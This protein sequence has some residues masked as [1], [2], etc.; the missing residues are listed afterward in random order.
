MWGLRRN[1]RQLGAVPHLSHAPG[2]LSNGE[3][4]STGYCFESQK[5]LLGT[6]LT[7]NKFRVLDSIT[8]VNL[9]DVTDAWVEMKEQ[10]N[11]R[12]KDM[13]VRLIQVRHKVHQRAILQKVEHVVLHRPT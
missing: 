8:A 3:D 11:R 13:P 9:W 4:P 2:W 6:N 12:G 7:G 5:H 10:S 1:T